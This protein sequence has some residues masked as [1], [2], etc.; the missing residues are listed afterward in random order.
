MTLND[1]I[2]PSD[3]AQMIATG[4]A[5][6]SDGRINLGPAPTFGII[7]ALLLSHAVVCPS[8]SR[9]L[10]KLSLF[11]GMINGKSEHIFLSTSIM[12]CNSGN[13][14]FCCNRPHSRARIS[15]DITKQC[16]C[17]SDKQLWLEQ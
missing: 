9:V 17:A 8:G 14:H 16:L 11:A 5:V 15:K 13:N 6:G 3:S 7:I 12:L 10:A 1:K 2:N 4:I